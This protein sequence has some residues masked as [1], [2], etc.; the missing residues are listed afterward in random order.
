MAGERARL[1][2]LREAAAR[3]SDTAIDLA[4]GAACRGD[5]ARVAELLRTSDVVSASRKVVHVRSVHFL[6]APRGGRRGM[7]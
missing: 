3:S 6:F 4:W 1:R 5:L 7:R 2:T